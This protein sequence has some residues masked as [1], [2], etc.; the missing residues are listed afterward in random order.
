MRGWACDARCGRST[1]PATCGLAQPILPRTIGFEAVRLPGL[2]RETSDSVL[3]VLYEQPVGFGWIPVGEGLGDPLVF[4]DSGVT[5]GIGRL[6]SGDA[7]SSLGHQSLMD[8]DQPRAS[9]SMHVCLVEGDVALSHPVCVPTLGSLR[10][11][12]A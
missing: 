4:R 11:L 2:S 8:P 3:H 1:S 10:H 6:E 12:V 5:Y 9:R 7:H